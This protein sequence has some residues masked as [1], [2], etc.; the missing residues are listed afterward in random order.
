[1]CGKRI[2]VVQRPKN[3]KAKLL[4]LLNGEKISWNTSEMYAPPTGGRQI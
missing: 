1:M 3:R 4:K 2:G